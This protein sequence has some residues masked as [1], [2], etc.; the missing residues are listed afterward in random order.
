MHAE[1]SAAWVP[2]LGID[3]KVGVLFDECRV[4]LLLRADRMLQRVLELGA[5]R[6]EDLALAVRVLGRSRAD[7]DA[8][9]VHAMRLQLQ[10]V[11]LVL[12]LGRYCGALIASVRTLALVVHK[13]TRDTAFAT[14]LVLRITANLVGETLR[15]PLSIAN[16]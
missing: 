14:P 8:A 7:L 4:V 3:Q 10:A 9:V 5:L 1:F 12:V 2:S 15:F 11:L 16:V 13:D 6:I